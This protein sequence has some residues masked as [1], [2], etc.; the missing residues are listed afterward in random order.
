[1]KRASEKTPTV[2]IKTENG[3]VTIDADQYDPENHELF[4]DNEPDDTSG[5]L[6]T[7][8][9]E[10]PMPPVP[11]N[12]FHSKVGNKHFVTDEQANVIDHPMFDADG[13]SSKAKFDAAIKAAEE[14]RAAQ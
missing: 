8:D 9:P 2:V 12:L 7:Q 1:M 13:Y 6:Q 3:P 5:G 4:E 11:E 14:A 10:P